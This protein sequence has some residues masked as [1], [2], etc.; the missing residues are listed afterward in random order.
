MSTDEYLPQPKVQRRYGVGAMTIWRW[1][2]NAE[3]GFPSPI[4]FTPNGRNFFRLDELL[5]FERKRTLAS[6][7]RPD[8]KAA[9]RAGVLHERLKQE[10]D[11][12]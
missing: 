4:K 1:V 11:D 8:R 9:R 12:D 6:I 7:K 5:E 10:V 2:H 3:L